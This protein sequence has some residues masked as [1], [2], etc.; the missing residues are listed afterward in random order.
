[1]PR[2]TDPDRTNR[3]HILRCF[4]CSI[5]TTDGQQRCDAHLDHLLPALIHTLAELPEQPSDAQPVV[6]WRAATAHSEWAAA[7]LA[8]ALCSTR[9]RW[10]A[11]TLCARLT[12]VLCELAHC[13]HNARLQCH[14]LHALRHLTDVPAAK[15]WVRG[16]ALA[17]LAEVN[18]EGSERVAE[19]KRALLRW[20]RHCNYRLGAAELPDDGERWRATRE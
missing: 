19:A 9:A 20:L 12:Q 13:K 3:A 7:A 4:A 18:C 16:V 8:A 5:Q 2:L 14:A 17:R 6:D 15:R 1:M 10:H 11:L